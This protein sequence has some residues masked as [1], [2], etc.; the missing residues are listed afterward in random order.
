MVAYAT[1]V[2]VAEL[3]GPLTSAE[4]TT[5]TRLLN[6]ASALVRRQVPDLDARIAAGTIEPI[7]VSTVVAQMVIRVLRN[8]EGYKSENSADYGYELDASRAAG[9]VYIAPDELA[10]LA[11]APSRVVSFIR[12]TPWSTP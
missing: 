6:F 5:A 7:V 8:P 12:M 2:D 11:A 9:Q 1:V 10:L 4:D 3:Y